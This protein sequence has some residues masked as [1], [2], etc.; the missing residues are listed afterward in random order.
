MLPHLA[1]A[2]PFA[3]ATL[4]PA[5]DPI[6]A[7][8]P[9]DTTNLVVIRDPLPHVN[10][11]LGSPPLREVFEKSAELQQELFGRRFDPV[12]LRALIAQFATF[13]PTE[14]VVAASSPA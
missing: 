2:V 3:V 9:A 4:L 10:A 12:S 6:L 14:T 5:Q 11:L 8:L 13:V 7:R 1:F